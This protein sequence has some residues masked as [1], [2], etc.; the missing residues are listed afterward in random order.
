MH[1]SVGSPGV[2]ECA[3]AW[4]ASNAPTGLFAR[5]PAWDDALRGLLYS[6]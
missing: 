2:M 1:L 4:A 6:Y 5:M 3:R